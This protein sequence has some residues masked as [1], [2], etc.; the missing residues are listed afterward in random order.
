[1]LAKLGI[2]VD[3]K[4]IQALLRAIDVNGNGLIEFEEFAT[5]VIYDPYK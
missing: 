3:R 2:Q 1:M 4:Y 5:L